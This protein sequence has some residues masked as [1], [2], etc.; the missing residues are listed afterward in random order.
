MRPPLRPLLYLDE[1]TVASVTSVLSP[2]TRLFGRQ[3]TESTDEPYRAVKTRPFTVH[4]IDSL[5]RNSRSK[6][7]TPNILATTTNEPTAKNTFF[8]AI[9]F[10][11][12]SWRLAKA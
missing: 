11:Y 3:L 10:F 8:S 5:T 9:Y 2:T 12:N 4:P 6:T 7:T 1:A